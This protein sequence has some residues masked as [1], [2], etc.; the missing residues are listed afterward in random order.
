MNRLLAI[1]ALIML[2]FMLTSAVF[3]QSQKML[4][5]IVLNDTKKPVSEVTINIPGSEPVYTGEDGVFNIARVDE[6]EWL[7]VTPLEGYSPKK[8][9]L[10]DQDSITIYLT[11][12]D[13]HSPYSEVLTPLENKSGRDIISSFKALEPSSFENWP[14]TSAEQYLEGTVSGTYVTQTSGMPGSGATVYIRGYS[15]L[16]SNNQ[17]LYIVDGVP[18][19]NGNIY[20][21]L[22]EGHNYSPIATIDPLDISEITVLKDAAST[23]LYGA[24]SANGVVIIKTLEPVETKTTIDFLFRTG[25]AFAPKQLP[26]LDAKSYKTLAN[27]ILFSSGIAEEDYKLLYPGLFL[28]PVDEGFV[29]YDHNTN[30]QDEVFSN[31][32]MNNIRFSIKGGDAVAK[33]GLSVGYIKKDGIIKNSSYDR[34]NIRLVGAFDI[35]SWL[36][37]DVASN[38]TTSSTYLEESGLSSVSNPLLSSLWK[39]PMLNPYEYDDDG[40]LL[41]IVDEVDELGT[42]NPTSIVSLSE[43][44]SGNYRFITSINLTGEITENLKFTSLIGLNSSNTKESIF[45]PDR[46]FDLL[47][48]GEVFNE[49]K[50]QNNSLFAIFN[51]NRIFYNREIN[52]VHALYGAIGFRWQ[53]TKYDQDYALARNTASDYF[54]NLNRGESLLNL[55]G[56]N[57][58]AWNWGSIYSNV[59]YAYADKYLFSATLSSDVSSRVGEN[60]S[61][62]I[63]MGDL[64][65]GIFYS[66]AV[67]RISY[68][69]WCYIWRSLN[70]DQMRNQGD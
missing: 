5:G 1:P 70:Q 18:L 44:Q 57:N 43:A 42:S 59:S 51:D 7:F 32:R 23:A 33:Y 25:I 16:L 11:S 10:I 45:I 13:I 9:L 35:F 40:N 41:N 54:T 15:S 63:K 4:S 65:V 19:E 17:P 3:G 47:Y 26:Q 53:K 68:L 2:N 31:G 49:S 39:S 56:G 64:P 34:L 55:I 22:L 6:K 38:L 8:I 30:W 46:G 24:K 37:M 20:D 52:R 12:N 67:R 58:R 21:G 61:N 69:R 62:T 27:E 60:A 36:T 48:Q 50:G 14:N 29:R 28:T 66:V